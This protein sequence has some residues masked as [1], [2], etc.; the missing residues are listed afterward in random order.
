MVYE[1]SPLHFAVEKESLVAVECLI[2]NGADV[3]MKNSV[4]SRRIMDG[5]LLSVQLK[6]KS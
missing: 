4:F 2:N 3:N 1:W 6:T 5:L